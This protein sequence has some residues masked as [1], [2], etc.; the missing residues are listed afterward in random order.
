MK[1]KLL[2]GVANTVAL[3][4]ACSVAAQNYQ[5]M[6][7]SS[8][9]NADVIA[10]GIGSSATSTNN[11]VDGVSYAFVARDFQLTSSSAALTY[12]IPTNG[13]ISS[14]VA[15]TPGLSYQLASLS[16]NNS[17]RL[18]AVNDAGTLAFATPK[19]ATKLYMLAVSGSGASTVSV[20][21]NFTDG[22]SQTFTG[23]SVSDWYGGTNYAIQGIGRVKKPGATPATGDDSPS[24]EGGTNPRLYQFEMAIDAAN[25]TKAI[26][27]ATVTKT[28]GSGIP[29]VFAFSADAFSTCAPP[30]L[31]APASIT[32]TSAL[33]SWTAPAS[34][35]VSYDVYHSTS[36]TTPTNTTTPTY[37]GVTGTNTTIGGL[38]SNTNYYYWVRT[39]CSTATSQSV[40]SF[41]G[42]FKTACSTFTV[43]YTENFDATTP[44]SSTNN[45]A[46]SCWS[47]LESASFA[48]YGYVVASTPYSTPNSYYLYNSSG[49]TGGQ[50]LVAPPTVGLSDGTKRVR[51]YARASSGTTTT[52][53]VG[54]LSNPTDPASF[55]PIGSPLALTTTY[56]MYTVNIPA[57]SDLQL[58]FKHGMA[59]A[60]QGIYIDNITVQSIPSCFEPTAVTASVVTTTS[61]TVN[62]TAPSP[63]PAT[64][65]SVYYS[66]SSTP[67]TSATVLDA[68]NS[69]SA[70]GTSATLTNLTPD[71]NYYIF[72]RSK[73]IGSD[74]SI[75]TDP[76]TI[77]TGYC[78]PSSSNQN[79][80]VSA[81]SSTGAV[82]NMAYT[83][84]AGAAGGYQNLTSTNNKISNAA[85]S[86]TA[87]SFTAGGPTCGF[88]VWVDWNNNLAFETTERVF[89][90]TSYVTSTS[91]SIAVPA[92]T[93]PGV[94]RMRVLTDF[95]TSAP[96]NSCGA[97]TRG[98]SIDFKFEV[99]GAL[100]TA[101]TAVKKNEVK[102]YPNP[103]TDVLY[104]SDTKEIK[105]VAVADVSGRVVK[106]IENPGNELHLNEL[107]A[108]VYLVTV[109]YKDGSRSTAKAIKK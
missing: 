31:Q 18:A 37:A 91:G 52:L 73:C 55:T 54:T 43:P 8:G 48:G 76:V 97:I 28:A 24:P 101:E 89:V 5:Q 83:S 46:P 63:A 35:V 42:T 75:W 34:S 29:N 56:G 95:N 66:T 12:G 9:F 98:E 94:Y 6:P 38:T 44:G 11:D 61:A 47:Y 36:N 86:S 58:A 84:T 106:T 45:N 104:I 17:L 1:L 41:A 74:T 19:A 82:T 88:A 105:S 62:W 109:T 80:W 22:T 70:T 2:F 64:G 96:S 68:T 103:F 65:Y 69:V 59:A 107:N 3:F 100:A 71:T 60:N 87:V 32:A 15:A 21:V 26:Q 67:P 81:F 53:S 50:M 78:V 33:V 10:N 20:V 77:R 72:V 7:V 57:G 30:V 108:G 92:G 23:V 93:A 49:V 90:T 99:T 13:L 4:A 79:S 85:G 51:F 102:V 27:S 39:N 14:A 16:A 25:Q 40:W